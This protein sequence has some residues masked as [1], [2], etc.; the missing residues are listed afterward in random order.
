M[1][2][3]AWARAGIQ[4]P[5]RVY[6]SLQEP[7]TDWTSTWFHPWAGE[8]SSAAYAKLFP[9]MLSQK[10]NNFPVEEGLLTIFHFEYF[11]GGVIS[12]EL[13]ILGL[14]GGIRKPV[15]FW[16][17]ISNWSM[18]LLP[19]W[20]LRVRSPHKKVKAKK[21]RILTYLD[22]KNSIHRKILEVTDWLMVRCLPS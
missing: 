20:I 8:S 2:S 3:H 21:K 17:I 14:N 18:Q 13:E 19:V 10:L 15:Y 11:W 22:G 16:C 4:F 1:G 7:T 5:L 9:F 12:M 6:R